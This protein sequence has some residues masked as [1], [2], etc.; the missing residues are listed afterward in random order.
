LEVEH[1]HS[2]LFDAPVGPRNDLEGLYR[3]WRILD[4]LGETVETMPP[5]W[6]HILN[7]A[8][9]LMEGRALP[10]IQLPRALADLVRP[11]PQEFTVQR[12]LEHRRRV[13]HPLEGDTRVQPLQ[14]LADLEHLGLPDI[15]LRDISPEVFEYLLISG[16]LN[17][18]YTTGLTPAVEEYDEVVEERAPVPSSRRR[19]Q[20]VYALLDVSN[21]MRDHNKII[22][23]KALMLAYL[24]TAFEEEAR[25][26]FRTFG[27]RVH[28][29]TDAF[30]TDGFR[31]LAMRILQLT[32]DGSTDIQAALA[33]AISD[34][35]DLEGVDGA[36]RT[37]ADTRTEIL[38]VS[39]CESDSVPYVPDGIKLHTVHLSSGVL[40]RSYQEGFERIRAESTSFFPIET[41]AL[42]LPE[43][44]R[45]RWLLRQDGRALDDGTSA[46]SP[47]SSPDAASTLP[48]ARRAAVR[49]AYERMAAVEGSGP[50]SGYRVAH[51]S[52][53]EMSSWS[54]PL[55][56]MLRWL[57]RVFHLRRS[58]PA[59]VA[60]TFGLTI[61]QKRQ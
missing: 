41:S 2:P 43:L 38:L 6:L 47:V 15:L 60:S 59:S 50:V 24:L 37:F 13:V 29:R 5:A 44:T 42:V 17:G 19:R 4:L 48:S 10:G 53:L 26:R 7:L 16:D 40:L 3:S 21:S 32:P 28:D 52:S 33:T 51:S 20:Q 30:G 9:N 25:I 49:A 1:V 45:E 35:R 27:N 56:P 36:R 18:V 55:R 22:F 23:A 12:R 34:I 58:R 8:R 57:G 46:A 61:R 54:N 31:E 11:A 39:D 14:S